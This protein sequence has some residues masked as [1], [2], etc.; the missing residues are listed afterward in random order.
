MPKTLLLADDSVTI[1]KVVGITFANEDVELVTVDNGDDALV[2]ARQIKP[3]L[4]LA[5][6]GMPGL[7]GYAL[8]GAIRKDPNIAHTPVLLLTGTFETYDE[9]KAREVG[10]N[11]YIS[12]P[13][14][15]Q[16]LVDRVQAMLA[17]KVAPPP[18]PVAPTRTI[19]V[20]PA[21]PAPAAPPAPERPKLDLPPMPGAS[22]AAAKSARTPKPRVAS[23]FDFDVT[24]DPT[25]EATSPLMAKPASA[26]SP[27]RPA[28]PAAKPA[29]ATS[30]PL[31]EAEPELEAS[32][33]APIMRSELEAT[34]AP[35]ATP[36]PDATRLFAPDLL[37]RP[38][39]I[40]AEP[41]SKPV[42]KPGRPDFS[43]GDLDFEEPT[44]S[45]GTQTQI[46][47]ESSGSHGADTVLAPAPKPT[48]VPAAAK[49]PAAPAAPAAPASFDEREENSPLADPLYSRTRFLDPHAA[50]PTPP[51]FDTPL[52]P[53]APPLPDLLGGEEITAPSQSLSEIELSEP[54]SESEPEIEAEP[55]DEADPFAE[56][57]SPDTSAALAEP[58]FA[59][60]ARGKSFTAATAAATRLS[61]EKDDSDIS[62]SDL[63][64]L[65]AET[66]DLVDA[67]ALPAD[68][69]P[70]PPHEL[71]DWSSKSA[72]PE[73]LE[74]RPT[75]PLPGR[76]LPARSPS[77]PATPGGAALVDSA[78]LAQT[79]EKV[80]WEA[81]GSLSEQVVNEVRKRVEAVVWEVVPQLCERL[82]REEIA[83]LKAELPE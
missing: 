48:P 74:T 60:V 36:A 4:V 39:R 8:C 37:G 47:G 67:E 9:D 75:A 25:T 54:E 68:P 38:G 56:P 55:I 53:L 42:P 69:L 7:D 29:A 6:I 20:A 83:R 80:A 24:P 21:A 57:F 27:A 61:F 45:P 41:E 17:Q 40:P 26:P 71:D 28:P 15:A 63:P 52:P 23:P 1:Q 35:A 18:R 73:P 34:N 70:E 44:G 62:R 59:P 32:D 51:T 16:A 77:A 49:P 30:A 2:R 66:D 10:A 78:L 13:F 43:F 19:A 50:S 33:D 5:D 72:E 79:L 81:F 22:S 11:G 3:D 31:W 65:S 12:K 64:P 58:E 46:F 76:A 82:I 14:E